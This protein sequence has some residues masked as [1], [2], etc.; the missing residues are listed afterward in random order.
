MAT[1]LLWTQYDEIY[2]SRD[3][4]YFEDSANV[5][6]TTHPN[7]FAPPTISETSKGLFCGANTFHCS[8]SDTVLVAFQ[9]QFGLTLYNKKVV[10]KLAPFFNLCFW[11]AGSQISPLELP[12]SYYHTNSLQKIYL[13]LIVNGRKKCYKEITISDK[14]YYWIR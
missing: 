6:W 7:P 2:R 4:H 3:Q 1:P 10:S 13:V 5:Y 8:L 14:R 12:E 11:I 9:N